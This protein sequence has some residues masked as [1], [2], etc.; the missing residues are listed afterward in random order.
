ME[1]AKSRELEASRGPGEVVEATGGD[2]DETRRPE[3]LDEVVDAAHVEV[4]PPGSA[5]VDPGG[6]SSDDKRGPGRPTEPPHV[7][8]D[9]AQPPDAACGA[10]RLPEGIQV[11]PGGYIA[12][13]RNERIA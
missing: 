2:A 10:P 8:E 5:Q 7:A 1:A 12:N 3:G 9:S 4:C 6:D 13:G 11:E